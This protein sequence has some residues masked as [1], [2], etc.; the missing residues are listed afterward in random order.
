MQRPDVASR[1][2]S[3]LRVGFNEKPNNSAHLARARETI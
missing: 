1:I 2:P 3:T